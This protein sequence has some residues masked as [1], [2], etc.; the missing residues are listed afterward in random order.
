[1]RQR[2]TQALLLLG[3]SYIGTAAHTNDNAVT[4]TM[5]QVRARIDGYLD[6]VKNGTKEVNG[7]PPNT[8]PSACALA[9]S[10]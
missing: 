5:A 2:V 6:A 3:I 10:C 9:V 7:V 4:L 8:E 1:M